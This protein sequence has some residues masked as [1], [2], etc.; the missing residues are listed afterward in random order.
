MPAE[1]DISIEEKRVYAGS[2][3]VTDVYVASEVGLVRVRVSGDMIGEFAVV[4]R[5][6]ARDVAVRPAGNGHGRVAVATTEGLLVGAGDANSDALELR[7][8]AFDRS[9]PVAV[10]A[11][12]N[13]FLVAGADGAVHRVTSDGRDPTRLGTV[14]DPRAVDPPLIAAADGV[15]RAVDGFDDAG[16]ENVGLADVRDV[17]AAGVPLA[18]TGD[19]LYWL[20]NG[21]MTALDGPFAAVAA[22]GEGHAIAAGDGLSVHDGGAWDADAWTRVDL[23]VP[24]SVAAVGYGPGIAVAVT[25][26]GAVCVDAGDGWRHRSVGVTGI[27]GV[28]VAGR[29]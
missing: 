11:D 20:G 12:R 23:P 2:A 14:E 9:A 22:D 28:A 1:D 21:W 18:A 10:G 6:A 24:G 19:G 16:L 7:P 13:G 26:S 15:H 3:G 8:A 4:H 17:S 5:T 29:E 25:G 27:G